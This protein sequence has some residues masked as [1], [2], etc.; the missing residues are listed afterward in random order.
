MKKR[1]KNIINKGALLF[2]TITIILLCFNGC[3]SKRV[4]P[5]QSEK[6][7]EKFISAIEQI[8]ES[9][10]YTLTDISEKST[11]CSYIIDIAYN[12]YIEVSFDNSALV[13]LGETTGIETFDAAYYINTK[14]NK[15]Y[16]TGLFAEIVN[17]VSGKEITK[18]ECDEFISAS[19]S[20]YP[21]DYSK[22]SDYVIVKQKYLNF[23][24]DWQL[25]YTLDKHDV[26]RL[27]F[28]GLTK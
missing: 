25:T 11:D 20:E 10:G 5:E 4:S 1:P 15:K 17:V 7:F 16:D 26:E 9:Y 24:E 2:L 18:E 6:N 3:Y 23:F 14:N 22:D 13:S 28:Y 19:E 21:I 8:I 12:E 27:S